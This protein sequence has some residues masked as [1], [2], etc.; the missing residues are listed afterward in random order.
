MFERT[1]RC[2]GFSTRPKLPINF[3]FVFSVTPCLYA[4]TDRLLYHFSASATARLQCPLGFLVIA[5][6]GQDVV[7][8][9]W[10]T[11][12]SL[13]LV[14]SS[15]KC[16]IFVCCFL[17]LKKVDKV[18]HQRQEVHKN[19]TRFLCREA[20]ESIFTFPWMGC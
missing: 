10:P 17:S 11:D 1:H 12:Q 8:N 14:G 15:L 20:T 19:G 4:S 7:G 9:R 5:W 13:E 18:A 2:S 3:P 6:K 16:V